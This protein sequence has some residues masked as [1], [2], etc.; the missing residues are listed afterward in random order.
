MSSVRETFGLACPKCGSDER[1]LVEVTTF[2]RLHPDGTES[3]GDEEWGPD[4]YC[5]CRNCSHQ[6]QVSAFDVDTLQ[7]TEVAP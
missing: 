3:A 7:D 4:S 6:A 5:E 2:V 1:I